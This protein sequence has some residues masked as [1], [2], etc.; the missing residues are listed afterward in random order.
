MNINGMNEKSSQIYS[1]C[2]DEVSIM[3]KKEYIFANGK[4]WIS[5]T[6]TVSGVNRVDKFLLMIDVKNNLFP[7]GQ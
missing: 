3:V 1:D 5:K 4:L 6:V 2:C 7:L